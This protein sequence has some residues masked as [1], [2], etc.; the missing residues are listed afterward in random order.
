M[1]IRNEDKMVLFSRRS[2]SMLSRRASRTVLLCVLFS[3]STVAVV[4]ASS[5][6]ASSSAASSEN[7]DSRAVNEPHS[8]PQCTAADNNVF[9]SNCICK[10]GELFRPLL[11]GVQNGCTC[12]EEQADSDL[13]LVSSTCLISYAPMFRIGEEEKRV[14]TTYCNNGCSSAKLRCKDGSRYEFVCDD[15]SYGALKDKN[16]LQTEKLSFDHPES[17]HDL[18]V[19]I[20]EVEILKE[21]NP[22]VIFIGLLI[23]CCFATGFYTV[24]HYCCFRKKFDPDLFVPDPEAAIVSTGG[25]GVFAN[26]DQQAKYTSTKH[27]HRSTT[28]K[29]ERSI[30]KLYST[31]YEQDPEL[32]HHVLLEQSGMTGGLPG[33]GKLSSKSRSYSASRGGFLNSITGRSGG[34]E[35]SSSNI[36]STAASHPHNNLPLPRLPLPLPPT[37]LGAAASISPIRG[38]GLGD[39]DRRRRLSQASLSSDDGG[40]LLSPYKLSRTPPRYNTRGGM[41]KNSTSTAAS[42][43]YYKKIKAKNVNFHGKRVSK[44]PNSPNFV[45]PPPPMG[46]PPVHLT[47][48][49]GRWT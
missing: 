39:P 44:D 43:Q 11:N 25:G 18:L 27:D 33:R 10:S 28:S 36:N 9:P 14:F 1:K 32:Y 2:F 48:A 31:L 40:D 22:I 37:R 47:G 42:S 8:I 26:H 7:H 21:K 4:S 29:R 6:S 35:R 49:G 38:L 19:N 15:D 24:L 46:I 17:F 13:K 41:K 34:R 16:G 20:Y 12:T 3:C 5:S 30:R 45:P 23:I